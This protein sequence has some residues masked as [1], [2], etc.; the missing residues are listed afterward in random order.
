MLSSELILFEIG[1]FSS[2][3]AFL[4]RARGMNNVYILFVGQ[5]AAIK[6]RLA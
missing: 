4:N 6:F 5:L 3:G 1:L 2:H